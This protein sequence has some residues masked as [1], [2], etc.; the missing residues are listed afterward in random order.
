MQALLRRSSV[1]A[2]FSGLLATAAAGPAGCTHAGGALAPDEG[3]APSEPDA[4]VD[5]GVGSIGAQLTL[6]GGLTAAT[7]T[8]TLSNGVFS[9]S[10]AIDVSGS[11]TISFV[12][13][14]I[15]SGA[16]YTISLAATATDSTVTCTGSSSPFDVSN[17]QTTLVHV[18][19][20]CKR[21]AGAGG[22]VIIGT[23]DNCPVWNTL[24]ANPSILLINETTTLTAAATAPDLSALKF[25]WS[26]PLGT[27]SG[28]MQNGTNDTIEFTCP[29]SGASIPVTL[30]VSDGPLSDGGTC[31]S[32]DT[33]G[34]VIVT[35]GAA[36]C[37]GAPGGT[38]IEATPNTASGTCPPGQVN[39][40]R[41]PSG[42]FCCVASPD[43][44]TDGSVCAGGLVPCIAPGQTCCVPCPASTGALCT[45]TEALIVAHDIALGKGSAA[46]PAGDGC[47]SCL[48][49]GGCLDDVPFADTGH[50]CGDLTGTFAAGPAAGSAQA[51][52]CLETASCILGTSCASTGGLAQGCFCGS[53]DATTCA[54]QPAT[55]NGPCHLQEVDGL[56]Q[57]PVVANLGAP[58]S[59]SGI[60]NQIFQCATTNACTSCFSPVSVPTFCQSNWD[61]QTVPPVGQ[62]GGSTTLSLPIA[63]DPAQLVVVW[64][65]PSGSISPVPHFAGTVYQATFTCPPGGGSIPVT[66]VIDDGPQPG[67]PSTETV[68]TVNVAC[69]APGQDAGIAEGSAPDAAPPTCD[70]GPLSPCTSA[71]QTCCVPCSG[72]DSGLCTQTE[73]AFVAH[74]IA[75]GRA[76]LAGETP[77][78]C[79]TCLVAGGC[80]DDTTFGDRG[81]EC[82]DFGTVVF[83]AGGGAGRSDTSLCL[84][85]LSCILASSCASTAPSRCYCGSAG[86]STACQ[87]N[88]APGPIDGP[89]AAAIA[90]GL[91]FPPSDGT[92]ITKN[93]TDKSKPSGLADQIFQCALSNSCASCLN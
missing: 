46:G 25:S 89:C 10:G 48:L 41:D 24:V 13:A 68:K 40:A 61:F 44:A 8:Y 45:P 74:D 2:I 81:N 66:A 87:G 60:A 31:P 90:D 76:T 6:P 12:I 52:L 7:L 32:N 92:D 30:V 22:V 21:E 69:P 79:Y 62:P 33:T 53:A 29:P 72:N 80:I 27:F 51:S 18:Q 47:Y 11:P 4:S 84:G 67:C 78:A 50:E 73:A 56:G 65:A 23:G 86:V 75:A 38:G 58:T 36:P 15:P 16:G 14:G 71:G 64:S 63:F 37:L 59:P 5:A 82:D 88:P 70:G 77:D 42:N 57:P 20:F 83:D 1:A 9:Q 43:A 39:G 93:L 17:R 55:G 19:M 3:R 26:A 85:A 54:A 91:G 49:N 34:T 28:E 35:C